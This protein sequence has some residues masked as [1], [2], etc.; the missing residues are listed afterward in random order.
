M[1]KFLVCIVFMFFISLVY[2]ETDL[3]KAERLKKEM[4]EQQ[5]LFKSLSSFVEDNPA[6]VDELEYVIS[7]KED[8][9][10]NK[11]QELLEKAVQTE[12]DKAAQ[13]AKAGR[14][15]NALEDEDEMYGGMVDYITRKLNLSLVYFYEAKYYLTVKECTNV[16]KVSPRNTTAWIRRGSGF[17]MLQ[18]YDDAKRD[19]ET[20]LTLDISPQDVKDVRIF[21]AKLE[22][23]KN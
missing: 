5:L 20:A 7:K 1:K 8:V 16:L 2:A 15:A 10:R 9:A 13:A 23:I 22:G 4:K 11:M 12:Q 6:A 21:L 18:K 14:A 19:W 17:F 3:E